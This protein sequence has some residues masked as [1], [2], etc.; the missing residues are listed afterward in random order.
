M[1]K[2]SNLGQSG[3]TLIEILM[4]VL[5]IVI[6]AVIGITQFTNFSTDAKNASTKANLAILRNSIS[7]MNGLE[8]VR[9]RKTTNLFPDWHTI[10]NNNITGCAKS[11]L[12]A[13]ALAGTV[14][15]ACN[16]TVLTDP[17]VS[18]PAA[19]AADCKAA[20][21]T[22]STYLTLIPLA[23]QPFVQNDIPNNPWTAP[24]A[25]V[26]ANK[27][28]DDGTP[29]TNTATCADAPVDAATPRV[30]AKLCGSAAVTSLTGAAT[31][32]G[33]CYCQ[34]TGQ[35]WANTANNDG[36]AGGTGIES[37]F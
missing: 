19:Y 37:T 27:V 28:T 21:A 29:A 20:F 8:R 9:C 6:M 11:D 5:V 18:P 16:P 23:D 26:A 12:A 25:T 35:I 7:A 34:S 31:E 15:A 32:S 30:N 10:V 13:A 2:V 1:K 4:A 33:W 24:K 3:F 14:A 36:G 17:N 22:G